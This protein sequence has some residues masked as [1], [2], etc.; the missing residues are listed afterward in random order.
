MSSLSVKFVNDGIWVARSTMCMWR[1]IRGHGHPQWRSCGYR[2]CREM[3]AGRSPSRFDPENSC[4]LRHSI[5]SILLLLSSQ[6]TREKEDN[7]G[8]GLGTNGAT[9]CYRLLQCYH[10]LK[11]T[12][13]RVYFWGEPINWVTALDTATLHTAL[14]T[15]YYTPPLCFGLG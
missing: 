8:L 12:R 3:W 5:N 11:T 2:R 13:N 7:D 4:E 1:D 15:T 10:C 6:D 14:N 9:E